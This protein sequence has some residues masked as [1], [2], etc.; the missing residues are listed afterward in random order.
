MRPS[1]GSSSMRE[2]ADR[3]A[4]VGP[5]NRDWQDGPAEVLLMANLDA[6]PRAFERHSMQDRNR[7]ARGLRNRDP[8]RS[9]LGEWIEVERV[10]RERSCR[11]QQQ[12]GGVQPGSPAE[13]DLIRVGNE[14]H[15]FGVL[16]QSVQVRPGLR[17]DHAGEAAA[18]GIAAH[19]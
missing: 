17:A 1:A 9:V 3:N 15:A 13:I 18:L 8:R 11:R 4:L 19:P 10:Q 5:V 2:P 6:E 7:Y 16:P 14:R 12:S